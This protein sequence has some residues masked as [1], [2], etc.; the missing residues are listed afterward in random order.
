VHRDIKLENILLKEQY[1][2]E[3]GFLGLEIKLCDLG[4]ALMIENEEEENVI[5]GTPGYIAPELLNW[6]NYGTKVDMF[7][8][9]AVMFAILTGLSLIDAETD[10][11]VTQ[12][13][14]LFRVQDIYQ[15]ISCY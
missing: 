7:S 3:K 4:L 2:R 11:E 9:G 8:V 1:F 5:C 13:N 10:E 12:L 14:Q 6:Q 15:K